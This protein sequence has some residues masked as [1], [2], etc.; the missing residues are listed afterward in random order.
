[1]VCAV[2]R[3]CS[4]AMLRTE[5]EDQSCWLCGPS[6][7]AS[8]SESEGTSTVGCVAG[9]IRLRLLSPGL[10]DWPRKKIKNAPHAGQPGTEGT[11]DRVTAK[12]KG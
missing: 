10:S 3:A 6:S 1:M 9:R 2:V 11:E 8:E 5:G 12:T 7:E 4:C